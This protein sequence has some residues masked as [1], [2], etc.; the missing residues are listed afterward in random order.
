MSKDSDFLNL[1]PFP[2]FLT[3]SELTRAV[4]LLSSTWKVLC[5]NFDRV[6]D[7]AFVP[8]HIMKAYRGRRGI[9]PLASIINVGEWSTSPSGCLIP[10]ETNFIPIE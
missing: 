6:T 8:V 3:L 10:A 5:S 2:F 4:T 1:T 7:S 9:A